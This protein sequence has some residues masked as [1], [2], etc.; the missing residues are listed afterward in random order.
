MKDF[1]IKERVT[2]SFGAQAF[3]L[4]NHPNFD[5]PVNDIAN[6]E[7]GYITRLVGPPTSI[8]GSFVGGDDSPRYVEV[9]AVLRF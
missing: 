9:K 6:P 7:F 1:A 5:Q 3:N 8:L 4:L 2:L